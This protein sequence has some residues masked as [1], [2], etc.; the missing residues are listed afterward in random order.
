MF[1]YRKFSLMLCSLI[2]FL[3]TMQGIAQD[4]VIVIAPAEVQS[5]PTSN[6][7]LRVT[8]DLSPKVGI[9]DDS[10][11]NAIAVD[12]NTAVIAG[13]SEY[14]TADADT[15]SGAVYVYVYENSQWQLQQKLV[16][17]EGELSTEFGYSV[18]LYGDTLVVGAKAGREDPSNNADPY[19]GSAH[20]FTRSN[21]LWSWTARLVSPLDRAC[22]CSF[23]HRVA[24]NDNFVFVGDY[25]QD[26]G[27]N[28][29]GGAVFV[30]AK[31][32]S[33][34]HVQT[35][36]APDPTNHEE[37]GADIAVDGDSLIVGTRHDNN[38]TT[39]PGTAFIFVYNQTSGQWEQQAKL[40]DLFTIAPGTLGRFGWTVEIDGNTAAVGRFD[41]GTTVHIFDRTGTTWALTQV[42]DGVNYGLVNGSRFGFDISLDGDQMLI[43]ASRSQYSGITSG[44][45]FMAYRMNGQWALYHS[46]VPSGLEPDQEFGF[47]VGL[48]NGQAVVG[49]TEFVTTPGQGN[50]GAA[51]F[52]TVPSAPNELPG[53]TYPTNNAVLTGDNASNW[54]NF[55]FTHIPGIE[56][57]YVWI[58]SADYSN[59]YLYEWFPATDDSTGAQS[60][61]GIC[62][63]ATNICRIPRD[64]WLTNGNYSWWM[65]YWSPTSSDF[66]SAWNETKFTVNFD[67]PQMA[68]NVNGLTTTL[69]EQ[70]ANFTWNRDPSALWYQIW[71]G[72]DDYNTT[73]YFDWVDATEICVLDKCTLDVGSLTF[74]NGSYEIWAQIWGP[75]GYLDWTDVSNA[76]TQFTIGLNRG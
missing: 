43:G 20:V 11:G 63:L 64:L 15:Q 29:N 61:S 38:Q 23:G 9:V 55:S 31:N 30:Y 76:P 52:F 41:G 54:D 1:K 37:F 69:T 46:F 33:W 74:Q 39:G 45:A 4:N 60:G 75:N 2:L 35:L 18:A 58:G 34:A 22:V 21:G 25:A 62:D 19:T 13:G 14:L 3:L 28:A 40:T 48:H 10:F 72:P 59:T 70:P 7:D 27:G 65:T 73:T 17:P 24:I 8:G 67:V 16:A 71:I 32:Q 57:Y 50:D 44:E 6:E 49:A 36:T 12:G 53:R 26:I 51:Y 47:S 68:F 56:W 42:I 5:I 66:T